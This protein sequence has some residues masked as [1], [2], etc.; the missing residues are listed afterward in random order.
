MLLTLGDFQSS[1]ASV[2][3][4]SGGTRLAVLNEDNQG[5][6]LVAEVRSEQP[7]AHFAG[8]GFRPHAAIRLP[9]CFSSQRLWK[10][11]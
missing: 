6:V 7:V 10:R 2:C 9:V 1:I 3:V 4:W 5:E 8:P 11:N